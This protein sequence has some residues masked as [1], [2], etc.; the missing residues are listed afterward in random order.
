MARMFILGDKVY[1]AGSAN[2]CEKNEYS[3]DKRISAHKSEA[4]FIVNTY[5][6]KERCLVC[7]VVFL[8]FLHV[9][10]LYLYIGA[11]KV[12]RHV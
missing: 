10:Q 5:T 2:E 6:V 4:R 11:R 1:G 3:N 7:C 8:V 9:P 12:L